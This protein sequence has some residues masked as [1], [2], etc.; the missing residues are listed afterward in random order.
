MRRRVLEELALSG[1]PLTAYEL[2]DLARD[3]KRIAPIT[4]YR[5]LEFLLDAKLIHRIVMRNA[6]TPCD[7]GPH[8]NETPVFLVC[9]TCGIVDEIHSR[10]FERELHKALA[11][12]RFEP[13]S[14]VVEIEG[15]CAE[16][17][18]RAPRTSNRAASSRDAP[19]RRD[20]SDL[21]RKRQADVSAPAL[22]PP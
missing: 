21:R 8:L 10:R 2:T 5:A 9:A 15:E 12:A 18:A 11:E 19:K 13:R 14:R 22:S 4:I 3:D 17:R 16:C 1:E 6:Y 20:R 7:H